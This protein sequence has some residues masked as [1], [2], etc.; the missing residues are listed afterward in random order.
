[1]LEKRLI[2]QCNMS[3]ILTIVILKN[4][5]HD[6]FYWRNSFT[7][8]L[9]QFRTSIFMI[10]ICF[11]TYT[12]SNYVFTHNYDNFTILIVWE[13]NLFQL[14]NNHFFSRLTLELSL[15]IFTLYLSRSRWFTVFLLEFH[16]EF[17]AIDSLFQNNCINFSVHIGRQPSSI[18]LRKIKMMKRTKHVTQH[19]AIFAMSEEKKVT[20]ENCSWLFNRIKQTWSSIQCQRSI[21]K[22]DFLFIIFSSKTVCRRLVRS[23]HLNY[24]LLIAVFLS[25]NKNQ[26]ML[27]TFLTKALVL[28]LPYRVRTE[29]RHSVRKLRK[30][31]SIHLSINCSS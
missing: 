3:R 20:M 8:N 18:R 25:W 5:K 15:C 9:T 4:T 6:I 11:K 21:H 19:S 16:G 7:I 13:H 31:C 27:K 14:W 17:S 23:R 22:R 1:M 30:S 28:L 24:L 12:F 2:L 29:T 26:N 10:Y